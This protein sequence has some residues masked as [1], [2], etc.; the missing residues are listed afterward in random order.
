VTHV[1][2]GPTFDRLADELLSSLPVVTPEARDVGVA[3]Y[4]LLAE[5]VPV[6]C[7]QLVRT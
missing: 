7:E 3:L 5:E 6:T 1:V 2:D 4:R